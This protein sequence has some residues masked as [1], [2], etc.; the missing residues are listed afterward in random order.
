MAMRSPESVAG[1]AWGSLHMAFI[2]R[3]D[4]GMRIE[5]RVSDRAWLGYA[6][7]LLLCVVELNGMLWQSSG[8]VKPDVQY[9][10]LA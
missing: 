7:A 6:R 2:R 8:C 3:K 5:I 1:G 4:G 10:L 9:M